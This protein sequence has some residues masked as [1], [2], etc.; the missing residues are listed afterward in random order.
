VPQPADFGLCRIP[1]YVGL[2]ARIGIWLNGDGWHDSQHAFLVLDGDELL[3]AMPG[4]ARVRPLTDADRTRATYSDWDLTDE[5]RAAICTYGRTLVGTP[6]SILDYLSL[7]L[8]RLRIRPPGLTKYI[9][10]TKSMICS[11]LVDTAYL[12]AGVHLFHDGR[13]SGDVTPGD[14]RKVLH[15]PA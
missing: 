13:W 14:L 15:G 1:G 3:E 9:A 10:S 2:A 4:G 8:V 12:R 11:Q 6:Y 5:Q 7:A